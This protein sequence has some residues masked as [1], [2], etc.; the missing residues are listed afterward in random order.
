MVW[1]FET[2]TGEGEAAAVLDRAG[3][4][5][6]RKRPK[7]R[8][9]K[10]VRKSIKIHQVGYNYYSFCLALESWARCIPKT[11]EGFNAISSSSKMMVRPAMNRY[12]KIIQMSANGFEELPDVGYGKARQRIDCGIVIPVKNTKQRGVKKTLCDLL[13]RN[14]F[15]VF[16]TR[17]VVK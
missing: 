3:D 2:K 16:A 9:R 6:D 11:T 7:Q 1:I 14:S 12:M 15:R 8:I 4:A 13:F 17:H 10:T 5:A